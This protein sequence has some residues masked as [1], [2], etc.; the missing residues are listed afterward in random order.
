[1]NTGFLYFIDDTFFERIKDPYLKV[2]YESTKRPHYFAFWD[3]E[4]SLYWFVPCSSR[5]EKFESIISKKEEQ[6]KPTDTIKIVHIQN[7]KTA[8]LFQDMFPAT[9]SY[10]KEQYKRGGQPVCIKDPKIIS[11][12]EKTAKKVITLLR[13]G[14]RFTPTQPDVNRIEQLM[15]KELQSTSQT[16]D[17]Q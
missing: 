12:L 17:I 13:R 5:I 1:M 6:H 2:N 7:R 4:T 16:M 9:K 14:V 3:S 8:L 10:I 11:N 15:L